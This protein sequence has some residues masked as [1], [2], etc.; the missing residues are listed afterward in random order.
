[1]LR[2]NEEDVYFP[3]PVSHKIPTDQ[4]LSAISKDEGDCRASKG[5]TCA[6]TV[7][8]ERAIDQGHLGEMDFRHW[9]F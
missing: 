7:A 3:P 5:C 9:L 2:N 4:I 6:I 1:M 8:S